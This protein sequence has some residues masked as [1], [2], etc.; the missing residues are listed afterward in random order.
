[1]DRKK[2]ATQVRRQQIVNAALEL[3]AG[4]GLRRLSM[5]AVA[6]RVGLVPSGIYRHFRNKSTLL[7]AVMLLVEERL[8]GNVAAACQESDN[9]LEQ[10]HGILMRH[11]QLI[12]QGR[13]VPRMVFSDD[14]QLGGKRRARQ[15]LQI[16]NRYLAAIEAVVRRGQKQGVVRR[17][18]EPHTTALLLLGIVVPAAIIWHVSD[19]K[20]DAERHA[21]RAWKIFLTAVAEKRRLPRRHVRSSTTIT[22]TVARKK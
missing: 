13:A 4:R 18:L 1:M 20:F 11:V 3:I 14:P 16:F 10:L 8:L 21:R 12:S 22:Q 2:L 6:R 15:L 19:G 5:A 17:A 9:A 7:D